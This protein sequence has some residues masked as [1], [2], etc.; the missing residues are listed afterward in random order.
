MAAPSSIWAASP[1]SRCWRPASRRAAS[2]PARPTSSWTPGANAIWGSP[3]TPT[4]AG[5][6]PARW[7]RPCWNN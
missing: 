6:P 7:W 4:A 2:I 1:T 5:P 3:M